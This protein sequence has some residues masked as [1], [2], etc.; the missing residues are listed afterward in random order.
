MLRLIWPRHN[1]QVAGTALLFAIYPS[2]HQQY[3]AVTYSNAFLVYV[4]FL[5]SFAAMILA[6]QTPRW[7]WLLMLLSIATSGISMFIAEYFF[8][9]ELLRPLLLWY[10]QRDQKT[11]L[12]QKIKRITLQWIPYLL[13]MVSFLVWRVF[14]HDTPRAEITLF[15]QLASQPVQ[16]ILGLTATIIEDIFKVSVL[17]WWQTVNPELWI[18][19]FRT[20]IFV[21]VAQ[22]S[23]FLSAAALSFLMISSLQ[24]AQDKDTELIDGSS[25]WGKQ[26]IIA[27]GFALLVGGWPF[28][29]TNLRIE[30]FFPNDRFTTPLMVGASLLLGGFI[31]L[32]PRRRFLSAILVSV[33]V[34]LAASMHFQGAIG[35][36]QEWRALKDWFWQLSWRAPQIEPGTII[37]SGDLFLDYYS[38]NS[39]TAPLN[40]TYA[41]DN[42]SLDLSYLF[43]DIE[44]RLGNDLTGIEPDLPIHS[45]YRSASF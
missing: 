31:A 23:I 38:D 8:G 22:I 7:Y 33:L 42:Y 45:Q 21:I 27:G 35:Y 39:L 13:L 17:A 6:I 18:S 3:I 5:L 34:G 24:K 19:A 15:D 12:M 16:A 9:L 25:S 14:L 40:W 11:N 36:R 44:A 32:I 37:L 2:F 10:L 28:W 20:G 4:L 43:M 26:A 30:L 1:A 41:P 29:P